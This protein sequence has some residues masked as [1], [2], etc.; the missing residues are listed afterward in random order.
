MKGTPVRDLMHTDF[1]MVNEDTTLAELV[2]LLSKNMVRSVPV[3]DA[4]GKLVGIISETDLFIKERSLP[5]SMSMDKVPTLLGRIID[6]QDLENLDDP[7]RMAVKD[8]M[9]QKVATAAPETTLQEAAMG[10]LH[11]GVTML[12]VLEDEALVGIVRR[13]DI[14]KAIF[15]DHAADQE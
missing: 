2:E 3:V 5:F 10:M 14:L 11:R 1:V 12:P 9:C 6:E 7:K 8:I 4:D 15:G 13:V